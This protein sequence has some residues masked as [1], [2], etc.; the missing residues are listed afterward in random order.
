MP[1]P[2][3]SAVTPKEAYNEGARKRQ[4]ERLNKL[5]LGDRPD[6]DYNRCLRHA[7]VEIDDKPYCSNHAGQKAL[8]ILLGEDTSSDQDA[9]D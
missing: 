2:Q 1:L 9:G 7:S 4:L 6:W 8:E 3:C 5:G